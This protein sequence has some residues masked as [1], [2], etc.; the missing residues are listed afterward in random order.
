[1]RSDHAIQADLESWA[2]AVCAT[3][4]PRPYR[5]GMYAIGD[6]RFDL[7][8]CP[9]CG[10][11]YC[12]PRP[13][14]PTL[15]RMYDDPEYYTDGYNLGVE[16][17]NYFEHRDELIEQYDSEV[18]TLEGE[19]GGP[20]ALMELGSAGGFFIEAA[21]RRGWQV[22][23]VELSPPAAEYSKREMGLDVWEGL[24]EDA[25]FDAGS[26]DVVVAD[27]VLEHTTDPHQVLVDLRR[28]LKPGGHALVVVPTY[29]NSLYFRTILRLQ[30][31]IPRRL[32]GESLLR[33]LKMDEKSDGG[34]P[35][36]ILE[37]DRPTLERLVR[38]AGFEIVA[39]QRS[40]PYPATLFKNTA[41]TLVQRAIRG[42]FRGLNLGMRMGV[43]PGARVRLL[44]RAARRA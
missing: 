34:Y 8:R 15:G 28:F 29:V 18:E 35:Y 16:T 9:G 21:R 11:V 13:D 42:V 5:A 40:V 1:M 25:P 24:L 41:P 37:F 7:S 32:L 22:K 2:C 30:R 43:L 23:G 6:V 10:L 44:A 4:D 19:V 36:H 27:N 33:L 14:G 39:V 20:G 31:L 12:Q 3:D 38:D 26:F 17:E